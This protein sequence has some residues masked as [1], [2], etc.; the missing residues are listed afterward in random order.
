MTAPSLLHGKRP[1]PAGAWR[2]LRLCVPA[3][4]GALLA[5]CVGSAGGAAGDSVEMSGTLRIRGNVPFQHPVLVTGAGESW[6]LEGMTAERATALS[7]R[8][9]RVRGVVVAPRTPNA[10]A[11]ILRVESAEPADVHRSASESSGR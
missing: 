5:A 11:A 10:W 7:G 2:L 6:D 8:A 3:L 9:V 1:R 4:A